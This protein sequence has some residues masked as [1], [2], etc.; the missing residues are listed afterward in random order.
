MRIHKILGR[1]LLMGVDCQKCKKDWKGW[2]KVSD[3]NGFIYYVLKK[4]CRRIKTLDE[5][6]NN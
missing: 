2:F 6:E 4:D 1:V 5:N 3:K